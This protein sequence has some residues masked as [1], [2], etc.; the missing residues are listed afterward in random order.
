MEGENL[1]YGR[2]SVLVLHTES[3]RTNRVNAMFLS[4]Y[5][6]GNFHT[7]HLRYNSLEAL[8]RIC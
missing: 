2:V 5:V 7:H 6:C 1:D 8:G 3:V 4:F